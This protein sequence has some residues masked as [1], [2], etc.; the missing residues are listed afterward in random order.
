MELSIIV[1]KDKDKGKLLDGSG[2]ALEA[3]TLGPTIRTGADQE[4]KHLLNHVFPP[5]MTMLW[6]LPLSSAKLQ[7]TKN[8]RSTRRQADA[9]NV[10]SKA[11]L[12]AIVLTR[13]HALAQFAPSKLKTTRNQPLP[14]PPPHLRLLLREWHI[15]Q[16]KIDVL[17]WMKCV[18][19][20]KIWIFRPPEYNGSC[21]GS[22]Q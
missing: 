20:E 11:I 1:L 8:V 10:E 19:L 18:L 15:C 21:S 3:I 2:V 17:S 16:K 7:M 6:T 5:E 12:F 9:L 4:I 22:S 14:S 13:R